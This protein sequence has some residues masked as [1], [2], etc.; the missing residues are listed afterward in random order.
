MGAF[1]KYQKRLRRCTKKVSIEKY[2]IPTPK[3]ESTHMVKPVEPASLKI[4]WAL[5]PVLR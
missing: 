4:E 3:T 5:W 1:Y 2:Q